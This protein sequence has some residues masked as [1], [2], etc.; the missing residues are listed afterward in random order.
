MLLIEGSGLIKN[1][2]NWLTA[3]F[4]ASCKLFW[5]GMMGRDLKKG[6]YD[7]RDKDVL[8]FYLGRNN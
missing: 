7:R 6:V 5:M 3:R 4:C 8:K 2:D 1:A